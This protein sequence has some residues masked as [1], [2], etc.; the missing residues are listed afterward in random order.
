[1]KAIDRFYE[2]LAEKNLKPTNIEKEM[3]L[4]NGYLS[5]QKKRNADMGEGIMNKI[6]DYFRDINPE[7]LLTG[8]GLMLRN[9]QKQPSHTQ[10]IKSLSNN[11]SSLSDEHFLYK[12]YKEK[13]EENRVLIRENGRLEERIHVLESK[14]Q[15]CQSA[16]E[17]NIGHP[18]DLN[19]AKGASIKKHSS[20]SNQN[21]SSVIAPL[22]D[23]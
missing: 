4:S 23:L 3:G 22:K 21:A 11:K 5:A 6:I 19:S 12:M 10:E 7:W 8:C 2:Y 18:K 13:D 15:E 16:L 9:N 14:L 17:L 20:Q 1:M